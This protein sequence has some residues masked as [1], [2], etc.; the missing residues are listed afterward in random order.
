MT[1]TNEKHIISGTPAVIVK[2]LSFTPEGGS[3]RILD[4]VSFSLGE[5]ELVLL[6]GPT[7][8]GKSTLLRALKPEPP[9]KGRLEGRITV[10]GRNISDFSSAEQAAAIGYVAQDPETQIVTDRV[11]SELAFGP[12]NIGMPPSLIGLR[13]A[14]AASWF[15]LDQLT[16]TETSV[17]S[18]G[19]KQL[20]NLASAAA[21]KPRL[22]LLDEPTAELDPVAADSFIS[23]V[24]RLVR[25]FGIT[26]IIAEHRLSA[27]TGDAD[28]L[29]I[30]NE[31]RLVSDSSPRDGIPVLLSIPGTL[32]EAPAAAVLAHRLGY[33]DKSF[34]GISDGREFVRGLK[35]TAQPESE[36]KPD[37]SKDKE[38]AKGSETALK[39]ENVSF[40]YGKNSRDVLSGLSF[41][42]GEGEMLSLLGGNG[43]GKSTVLYTAAGLLSPYTGNVSV[44]GKKVRKNDGRKKPGS[45]RIAIVP[46]NVRL[47]FSGLTVAEELAK[48]GVSPENLPYGPDFDFAGIAGCCSYDL[49]GGE[50]HML[51]LA[52]AL[53]SEPDV[54]LLDEPTCGLDGAA[55]EAL[56]RAL[57]SL[58]AKGV[59]I[60]TV[61]HSVAFAAEYSD[62]VALLFCGRIAG[63]GTPRTFFSDAAFFT[64]DIRRITEGSA[65]NAVTISDALRFFEPYKEDT[66]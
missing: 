66:E 10:C 17:L 34:T 6:A 25:E 16:G 39:F 7:G 41:A 28:R 24:K 13:V 51:G 61:T 15:G 43:A 31:G 53:A 14:E 21:L 32:P 58:K 56:G 45:G 59:A 29:L 42:V 36:R 40:R 47:L 57:M 44:Y 20:L 60:I 50:A 54:L 11:E 5:G 1:D 46:Q 27:L 30:L 49:S 64:T 2:D 22:L 12:E 26:V 38:A 4:S 37:T 63:E 23:A 48:A 8:S 35:K 65:D 55:T 18:G 33:P 3:R 62:R 52:L 9:M 19:K